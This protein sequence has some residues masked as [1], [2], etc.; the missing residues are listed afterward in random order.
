MA[1]AI[2]YVGTYLYP[3]WAEWWG[4]ARLVQLLISAFLAFIAGFVGSRWWFLVLAVVIAI[5]GI[6]IAGVAV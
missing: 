4:P 6:V 5:L 2:L 1:S 3:T